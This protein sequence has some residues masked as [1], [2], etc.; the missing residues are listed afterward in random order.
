MPNNKW[1]FRLVLAIFSLIG[2]IFA[3]AFP[4]TADGDDGSSAWP[5]GCVA[6]DS[7]MPGDG[8]T[9][10]APCKIDA[11]GTDQDQYYIPD[12]F[13]HP[14]QGVGGGYY[15][16]GDGQVP[17]LH[18]TK[19]V[20]AITVT[21][22]GNSGTWTFNYSDEEVGK[23]A[24]NRYSVKIG[25]I[26]KKSED[27]TRYRE[28]T[29]YFTNAPDDTGRYVHSIYPRTSNSRDEYAHS[30]DIAYE[31]G[32]GDTAE[33]S[34]GIFD[35]LPGL[36]PGIW[37]VVFWRSDTGSA[38]SLRGE[39]VKRKKITVLKCG[40]SA[41]GGGG[42]ALAQG[43]LKRVSCHAVKVVADARHFTAASRAT[44]RVIKKPFGAKARMGS[45][46]VAAGQKRVFTLRKP[47]RTKASVTLK[48]KRPGGSWVRLDLVKL[49]H[50]R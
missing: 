43:D 11:S 46:A 49:P 39:I 50:C 44:Y 1:S 17:G 47:G 4:A 33:M 18:K 15:V 25:S 16:N 38:A 42:S 7:S 48:V 41:P 5:T 22:S 35:D 12:D 6:A 14:V 37:N 26:C 3:G 20:L 31:I 45:F 23:E 13:D 32:D 24:E 40:K 19:G 8:F 28:V 2:L 29:A 10:P 36:T 9:A 21:A 27:G 30:V 34:I